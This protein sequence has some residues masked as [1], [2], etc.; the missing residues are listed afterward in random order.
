MKKSRPPYQKKKIWHKRSPKDILQEARDKLFVGDFNGAESL[1]RRLLKMKQKSAFDILPVAYLEMG[2]HKKAL[3]A[4]TK[5]VHL[6]PQDANYWLMLASLYQSLN[7]PGESLKAVQ[8]A[9]KCDDVDQ[10]TLRITEALAHSELGQ[11]DEAIKILDWEHVAQVIR[12]EWIS[13]KIA[14]LNNA[15]KYTEALDFFKAN[16]DDLL[17]P[18][19]PFFD[20]TLAEV[21]YDA[22]L[23]AAI[24]KKSLEEV[25][26][27]LFESLFHDRGNAQALHLLREARGD[28]DASAK[29]WQVTLSGAWIDP[30]DDTEEAQTVEGVYLVRSLNEEQA[31]KFIE[32]VELPAVQ[33]VELVDKKVQEDNPD[34]DDYLGVIRFSELN[35]VG[36]DD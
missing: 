8:A 30:H 24:I 10:N 36:G 15:E 17:P 28:K 29:L 12:N 26:E 11:H 35:F 23:A 25:E 18:D 19:E 4:L 2:D 34:E 13:A 7:M 21:Y 22:A 32:E 16:E 1:G 20:E 27:L 33:E 31:L 14:C 5:A 9:K 3:D 6:Y